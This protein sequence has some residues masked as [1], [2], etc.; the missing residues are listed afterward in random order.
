M[1]GLDGFG[2][3]IK[4]DKWIHN[5]LNDMVRIIPFLE[6]PKVTDIA[7]GMGGSLL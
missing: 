6:N 5:L 4:T 2:Q 7:I 3:Q 1:A